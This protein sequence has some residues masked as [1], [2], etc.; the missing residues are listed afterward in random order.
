MKAYNYF[1]IVFSISLIFTL[2]G[3]YFKIMHIYS[4]WTAVLLVVGLLATLGYIVIGIIEVQK[5]KRISGAEKL[6][7]T[8]GFISF[9]FLTAFLYLLNGQKRVV[10]HQYK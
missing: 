3:A 8:V 9:G 1:K 5:S 6:M 2:F 7:W 10:S 4:N